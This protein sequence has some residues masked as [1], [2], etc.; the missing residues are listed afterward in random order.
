M[1]LLRLRLFGLDDLDPDDLLALLLEVGLCGLCA[2]L[3]EGVLAGVLCG[4]TVGVTDG[5]T[6]G[7]TKIESD[8]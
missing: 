5:V 6:D 4:V 1:V 3:V 7:V 8:V 2:L